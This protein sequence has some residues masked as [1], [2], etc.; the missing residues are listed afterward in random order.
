MT[1]RSW[2]IGLLVAATPVLDPLALVEPTVVVSVA[3]RAR[4]DR[5]ELVLRVLPSGRGQVAVFGATRIGVDPVELIAA[6]NDIADL[7]K[8]GLV[9]AIQRFSSPPQAADLDALTLD[10]HD[11][12]VLSACEVGNCS[13]KLS[14]IEI[15]VIRRSRYGDVDGDRITAAL[16]RVMLER[17]RA[18]LS[19]GLA[20]LPPIANRSRPWYLHDVLA[21]ARAESPRLLSEPPLS[22][23]LGDDG[24]AAPVESFLYWSKEHFGTGK[25]VILITHVA[26]YRP[27]TGAAVV[28]GKQIFGSR[29][30]NGALS[31]MAIG[32]AESGDRYLVYLNRSTVDLLGGVFGGVK[33]AMLEA[34]L[35]GEL[36]ELIGRLRDRLERSHHVSRADSLRHH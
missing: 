28:I 12:E 13:F 9:L 18:Y 19:A 34:R 31:M 2:L 4:L 1:I 17:T 29:Y 22:W 33:R 23:W 16:R 21:A 20:A 25:P 8:S 24:D 15:E 32:T 26:I 30:T 7:R 36:P 35:A 27:S 14:A 6:A 5:G 3:E 11:R 10:A